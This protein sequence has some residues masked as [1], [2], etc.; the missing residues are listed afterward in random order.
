MLFRS[1]E[2]DF[3]DEDDEQGNNNAD[4]DSISTITG[5]TNAVA[6]DKFKMN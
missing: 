4:E 3:Y 1:V 5:G 6:W 2:S